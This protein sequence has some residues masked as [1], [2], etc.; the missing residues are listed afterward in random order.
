MNI[1]GVY[2]TEANEPSRKLGKI[3]VPHKHPPKNCMPQ[4]S[5]LYG[6]P[7]IFCCL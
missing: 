5:E 4:N 7:G 1:L 6:V 2:S 3:E